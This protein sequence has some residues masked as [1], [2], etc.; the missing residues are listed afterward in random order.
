[1]K[2]A[3]MFDLRDNL[4]AYVDD[5]AKNKNTVLVLRYN[6]PIAKL[7]AVEPNT[8]IVIPDSFFGFMGKSGDDGVALEN[9]IRRSLKEKDHIEK[10]RKG[11]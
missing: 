4:A 6:K 5:V 9:K 8:N 1:M 11:T 10:L 2:I 7:I 3:N